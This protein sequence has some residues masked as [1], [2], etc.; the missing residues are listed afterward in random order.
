MWYR[1]DRTWFFSRGDFSGARVFDLE[2]DPDCQVDIAEG[3][4]DR[5][6]LARERILADAGGDIPIYVRQNATDA[7]GRPVFA[8]E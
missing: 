1:D 5:I 7:L 2:A 4:E 3:A 8:E 6:G